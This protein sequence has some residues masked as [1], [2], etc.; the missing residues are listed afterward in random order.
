MFFIPMGIVM[1]AK[2]TWAQCFLNNILPVTLGNII[3]GALFV[4]TAFAY[5]HGSLGKPKSA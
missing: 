3:G 4:G 2:V 5:L 1:G